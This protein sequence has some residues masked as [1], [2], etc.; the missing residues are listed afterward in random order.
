[1]KKY[2]RYSNYIL[3]AALA[4]NGC[5]LG[6]PYS[7]PQMA[8]PVTYNSEA[9]SGESIANLPWWNLFQDTILQRIIQVGI[10]N[11][12]DLQIAASRIQEAEAQM[13]VVRANLY[14]RV[15]YGAG[16]NF[17]VSSDDG[18]DPKVTGS[19][20]ISA[21]WI[22]DIW[23]RYRNLSEAAFN[24][25]LASEEAYRGLTLLI[26][27][28]IAQG[29]L[30][31]RDLD[32]RLNVSE[33]TLETWQYN[34]DLVQAR[35]NAGIISEVDVKQSMIQVEEARTTIQTFTRLRIQTENTLS[36]LMGL[37]PQRI[38]RGTK[39]EEQVFPPTLPTGLPSELLDRRPD[40]MSAERSLQAQVARRNAT[41]AL[42]YPQ[43]TLTA[44]LTASFADPSILF[45]NLGAQ[46][47]GP[48]F[49]SGENKRRL[50][51]EIQRTEQL[52]LNYQNIFLNALKEVEDALIAVATY[53]KEFE[54][55]MVQVR[56][57][58]EALDMAWVRYENGVT[59][60]LEI[61]D[62]QRSEFNSYL[63]ASET[64]QLQLTSSVQLYQALGGGWEIP[65]D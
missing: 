7:R 12:K 3:I 30:L 45:G 42:Q 39:L 20:A 35:F 2:F 43:L 36:F 16:G 34:L 13:G 54:S 17:A 62:L 29:Y 19:G 63:K 8:A 32:N 24:E 55:R 41:E 50:E 31:L 47:F 5:K 25:Y 21:S 49:N 11:N 51:V 4:L 56:A 1:M 48:L 23:G 65:V 6:Q 60:Y 14:P 46:V 22:L 18:T 37:P 15:N 38:D 52:L 61:L 59:S 40:L 33:R 58:S 53:E 9:L 26:V 57:A 27:S 64:L 44:D 10:A 28:S